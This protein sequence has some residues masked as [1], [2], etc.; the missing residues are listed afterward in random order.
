MLPIEVLLMFFTD[1]TMA[2]QCPFVFP[3]TLAFLTARIVFFTPALIVILVILITSNI[4]RS[5]IMQT[6]SPTASSASQYQTRVSRPC[7]RYIFVVCYNGPTTRETELY[8][9]NP[10]GS[11]DL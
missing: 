4:P 1:M 11:H 6:P 3:R 2:P 10:I 7:Q 9:K 5:S 8:L